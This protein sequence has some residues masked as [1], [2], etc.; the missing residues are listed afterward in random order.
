[1]WN[2]GEIFNNN[3]RISLIFYASIQDYY[4]YKS[5]YKSLYPKQYEFCNSNV[6][7]SLYYSTEYAS[8]YDDEN[9]FYEFAETIQNDRAEFYSSYN[10]L[11]RINGVFDKFYLN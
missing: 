1:V 6:C 5:I 10:N 4:D 3:W 7:H 9:D 2:G 8:D 11:C